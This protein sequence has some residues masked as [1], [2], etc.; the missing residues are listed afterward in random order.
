MLRRHGVLAAT[1]LGVVVAACSTSA[2]PT[3]APGPAGGGHVTVSSR[4]EPLP[5]GFQAQF[6][7]GGTDRSGRAV[8]TVTWQSVD[9]TVARVDT[10]GVVTGI[11]AGTTLIRAVAPDGAFGET[12]IRVEP[13]GLNESARIGHD[14]ELGV[15]TDA[16]PSDDVLIVRRQYTLSYNPA[17]GGP[18]W[19]SWDLSA[20]HLGDA[21]R[22]NCFTAD[23]A[24]TRLGY[25]APTTADYVSGGQYDRGHMEPS[26]DQSATDAENAATFILTNVLPQRHDLNA[27]PWERLEVALRDSVRA[28]REVYTIAGGIFTGGVGLGTVG[29]RGRIAIPDSTWKIAVIM[30]AGR[31]LADIHAVGDVT[32]IAVNMPN[33]TGIQSVPWPTYLT[34]VASIERSTGYDFLSA[35]PAPIQCRVEGRTCPP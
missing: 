17:R 7:A 22:C 4:A 27:G 15:P 12:S 31:G 8:T 24:L 11:R 28:G 10:S 34:T 5:V 1:L 25:P 35:L 21:D 32:V 9:T 20:T 26:A 29:G 3:G 14:T 19:V 16:D 30:P 2:G 33:V 18:N 23:T 6:F 13:S